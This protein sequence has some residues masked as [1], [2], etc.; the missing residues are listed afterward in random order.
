VHIFFPRKIGAN[1]L[2]FKTKANP[3]HTAWVWMLTHILKIF[4]NSL[5]VLGHRL[6]CLISLLALFVCVCVCVCVSVRT[7]AHVG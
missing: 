6:E 2:P 3:R 5:G 1:I 7:R 4:L